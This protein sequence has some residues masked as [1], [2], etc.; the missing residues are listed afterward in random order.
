MSNTQGFGVR[1]KGFFKQ[2]MHHADIAFWA[3]LVVLYAFHY[4][5]K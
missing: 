2:A 1:L 3:V 5:R 4:W